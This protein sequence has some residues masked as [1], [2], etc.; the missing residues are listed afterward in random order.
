MARLFDDASDQYLYNGTQVTGMPFTMAC[1]F[2]SNDITI[3]QSLMTMSSEDDSGWHGLWLSLA[4]AQVGDYIQA[5][6]YA[7]AGVK[8][9]KTSTGY[10]AD[11]WHH[12]CGIFASATDRRAY[13]DGGSKGTNTDSCTP[14]SINNTVIG[15]TY[16]F[17]GAINES[18]APFSG[19][20]AGAAI[21]NVA[22]TDAEVASLATGV[23]PRSVRP[24]SL[25]FYA[26]LWR[27]ED[28]DFVGGLSLTPV[29]TPTVAAHP[30]VLYLALP[31]IG[32]TAAGG[33]GSIGEIT[34]V[35]WANVGQFAGVAEASISQIAGVIAN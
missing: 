14:L 31:Q 22:L 34:T 32:K 29:N 17:T 4:G 3:N 9:A 6:A 26:P 10:S 30:R 7:G 28:E 5:A 27:D 23:S 11:T 33:A 25:V 35:P 1:W 24:E 8:L 21:W 15:T 2:N 20:I 18:E 13:I 16:Y 19:A 12:A